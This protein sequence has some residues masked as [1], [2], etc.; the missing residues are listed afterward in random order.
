[1][2]HFLHSHD[3]V[4][5]KS[6]DLKTPNVSET[7]D[8]VLGALLNVQFSHFV[9]GELSR[10]SAVVW[11]EKRNREGNTRRTRPMNNIQCWGMQK[12]VLNIQ[13]Q[14]KTRDQTLGLI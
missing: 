9:L 12:T 5:S 2:G 6:A 3:V 10:N 11:P 7:N 8:W 4:W 13:D 14:V 1:M